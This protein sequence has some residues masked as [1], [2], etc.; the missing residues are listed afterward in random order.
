MV[1]A[2]VTIVSHDITRACVLRPQARAAEEAAIA[3]AKAKARGS[4]L[5][6]AEPSPNGDTNLSTKL[7]FTPIKLEY[8]KKDCYGDFENPQDSIE[9]SFKDSEDQRCINQS[10]SRR[11]KSPKPRSF[12]QSFS[13][14]FSQSPYP[15]LWVRLLCLS[16]A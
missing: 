14:S 8:S 10:Q 2:G 9:D 13:K 15:N 16:W 1:H 12:S 5:G 3:E 4:G 7:S 11:A 6:L